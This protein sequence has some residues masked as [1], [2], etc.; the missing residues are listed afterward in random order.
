MCEHL[1]AVTGM[2]NTPQ[3]CFLSFSSTSLLPLWISILTFLVPFP[4]FQC[5]P[6]LYNPHVLLLIQYS[7]L[8]HLTHTD[9]HL[10]PSSFC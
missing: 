5:S 10:Q 7:L 1:I 9:L 3:G 6:G 4:T 2:R 8:V